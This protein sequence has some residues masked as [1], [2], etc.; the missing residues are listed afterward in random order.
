MSEDQE[1]KQEHLIKIQMKSLD[2]APRG[3]GAEYR[4][5]STQ[6]V[7]A[8]EA[9]E[10]EKAGICNILEDPYVFTVAGVPYLQPEVP[11]G[12]HGKSEGGS[13]DQSPENPSGLSEVPPADGLHNVLNVTIGDKEFPVT[14]PQGG[15][16]APSDESG[17]ESEGDEDK[18]PA[19]E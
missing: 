18:E 11:A 9:Y 8:A 3:K 2:Y 5:G 12:E 15:E 10:L 14:L 1:Q 4:S 7:E 17:K 19:K 6:I 16:G 13:G